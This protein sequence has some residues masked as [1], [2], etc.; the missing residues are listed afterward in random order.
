MKL[1]TDLLLMDS[2]RMF[3]ATFLLT[4]AKNN[5][6]IGSLRAFKEPLVDVG[7][8]VESAVM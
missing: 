5:R 2:S 3:S 4:S 1:G 8:T 7:V 6:F